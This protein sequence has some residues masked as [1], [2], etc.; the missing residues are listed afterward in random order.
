MLLISNGQP[1][2]KNTTIAALLLIFNTL[3]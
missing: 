3:V 1:V 2:L